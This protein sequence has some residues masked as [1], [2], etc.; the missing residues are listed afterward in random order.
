MRR[1]PTIALVAVVA[2]LL[3][4]APGT[5]AV[6]LVR[7]GGFEAGGAGWVQQDNWRMKSICG[8]RAGCAPVLASSHAGPRS[9]SWWNRFGGADLFVVAFPQSS[10]I[11]QTVSATS[12]TPLTLS[13]WLYIGESNQQAALNVL[14]DDHVVFATRGN[15]PRFG[16][17]YVPIVVPIHGSLVTGG[18]QTLSFE[19]DSVFGIL[20][21]HV[22]NI[23][24]VSLQAPDVDLAVGLASTPTTVVQGTTFATTISAANVGPHAADDVWVE[25]PLPAGATLVGLTGDASCAAPETAP[26]HVMHCAFG[27]LPGGTAK[28]VTATFSADAVGTIAQ[29]ATVA[30]RTGDANH[31]NNVARATVTVVPPA[32]APPDPAKPKAPTCTPPRRFTV[33]IRKGAKGT[34]LMLGKHSPTKARILSARLT[35]SKKFKTRKLRHS[36]SRVTVDLRKLAAGRYTVRARVRV[37]RTRTLNVTRTYTACG[38]PKASKSSKSSNSSKKSGSSKKS[39]KTS[40]SAK[41]SASSKKSSAKKRGKDDESTRDGKRSSNARKAANAKR[42]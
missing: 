23:D 34:A 38:A 32:G 35:G 2:G 12:G 3:L 7:D 28:A 41:T 4:M 37:S 20:R 33:P 9:G 13:F 31:A 26:G 25:Y 36:R 18:P 22:I 11:R 5:R 6:E 8:P 15:D 39:S 10:S 42:R 29:N 21:T 16:S 27:T 24:D 17:G 1:S 30:T 40:K 14:L 19:F